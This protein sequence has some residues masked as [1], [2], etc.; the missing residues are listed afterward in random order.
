MEKLDADDDAL[1]MPEFRRAGLLGAQYASAATAVLLLFFMTV[2]ALSNQYTAGAV[3]I[4]GAMLSVLTVIFL[5]LR[6][7]PVFSVSHY[8]SMVGG[9]SALMLLG[10]AA[11]MATPGFDSVSSNF[12][13]IPAMFLGLF[14][15]YAFLRLPLWT[16]SALC[17]A[18]SISVVVAVP[19]GFAGAGQ[20]RLMLYLVA[21]NVLGM[22]LSRSI[23]SRERALF[24]ERRRAES[25]ETEA[26]ER[27]RAAEDAHTE[28]TRLLAAVSHDLRQPIMAASTHLSV[29]RNKL[30]KGELAQAHEQLG[31][32][33]ESVGMLGSTLDHLLTAARYDSGNE[34][35][36]I[37]AVELGPVLVQIRRTFEPEAGRKGLELRVRLP[38][39][40]VVVTSDAT[41]LWR[42][43]MN[44]VSNAIKFTESE[45]RTGRG[46]V[47]KAR[48]RGAGCRIDVVD[49]GV[50]ISSEH[51]DAIWQ[52]YFQVQNAERSRARGLGLGLFLVRRALDQLPTHDLR[53]RSRP[54][55]G[56]RFTLLLP[57]A[58]L[59]D[60]GV[61]VRHALPV[62]ADALSQLRGAY[63]LL[64]E[65][66]R[67]AR[68]A[69]EDLLDDWGVVHA[70]GA[71]LEELIPE[72]EAAGRT[73]DVLVTDFR[74]PGQLSGA[75][76]V[77]ELRRLIGETVPAV[78]V[79]G[80][81]DLASVRAVMPPDTALLQKPFEE[82]AFA[83]PL[84]EAV[85]RARRAESLQIGR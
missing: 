54:G 60:P 37:E 43:L 3:G 36:R 44:L 83:L 49:T 76:C 78:I 55:R 53:W 45:G 51:M 38:A 24:T 5:V 41:A 62:G 16:V 7:R 50:G 35:I 26:R 17:W 15:N 59:S 74:L 8:V 58:H 77:Q 52:A 46:V 48:V 4:R 19:Q 67:E 47:V 29:L 69:I 68:R 71:T 79:T 34:P 20:F 33:R 66:D 61:V 72:V 22:L 18:F 32:V 23:E 1:F 6:L 11:L 42:V 31:H 9:T 63:V 10:L 2:P 14:L 85:M 65:D 40:R 81:S 57:G 73:P 12:S 30:D 75:A 56:S 27:A 28:K 70:S 64:L 21:L 13:P 25:A 80:E 82:A 39:Q 84:L